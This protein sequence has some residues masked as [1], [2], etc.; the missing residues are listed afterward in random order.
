VVKD[1]AVTAVPPFLENPALFDAIAIA[2]FN[3]VGL[4]GITPLISTPP[5][6]L[7]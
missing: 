6:Y 3:L 4:D 7:P 1:D 5:L 2:S